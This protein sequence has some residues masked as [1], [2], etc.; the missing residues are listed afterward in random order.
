MLSFAN[1]KVKFFTFSD[2]NIKDSE[3][4]ISKFIGDSLHDV[5]DI[6]FSSSIRSYQIDRQNMYENIITVMVIYIQLWF[7]KKSLIVNFYNLFH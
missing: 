1:S 5:K 3:N 2:D 6:Q 7:T 4:D